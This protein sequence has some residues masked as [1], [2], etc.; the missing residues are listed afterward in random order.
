VDDLIRRGQTEA[1]FRNVNE[2]IAESAERFASDEA[3][4]VCECGDPTC[5]DR[6]EAS[7]EQYEEVRSDATTFLLR[8]GHED[9]EIERVVHTHPRFSVVRKV[10]KIVAGTVRRL[11][12]R[13]QP[14]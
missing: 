6:I 3:E 1:L 10:E 12:P 14:A 9:P 8:H 4:F 5:A 2:H 13:S 7:L 11:D